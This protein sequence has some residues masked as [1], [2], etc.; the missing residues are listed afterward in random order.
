MERLEG[1][2]PKGPQWRMVSLLFSV[3]LAAFLAQASGSLLAIPLGQ[4]FVP[5]GFAL[6]AMLARLSDDEPVARPPAL[7]LLVATTFSLAIGSLAL[8][9]LN[10]VEPGSL[11]EP[12][13]EV[14]FLAGGEGRLSFTIMLLAVSGSASAVTL[15]RAVR[16]SLTDIIPID[17]ELTSHALGLS[18]AV[19]VAIVP[20]LPLLVLGHAPF[21]LP[22]GA[23]PEDA[24]G[25]AMPSFVERTFELGWFALATLLVAGPGSGRSW[26]AVIE[27]LGLHAP[28][29][30]HLI[31][32][33]VAGV[34][35]AFLRP[36]VMTRIATWMAVPPAAVPDGWS[37]G[38]LSWLGLV[39]C[40]LVTATG[41][42]LT[43][44]GLLQPRLG[45]VF[46]NLVWIAPL[47]W[48]ASWNV[49]FAAFGAGLVFG[50]LR[51]ASGTRAA[52]VAHVMFLVSWRWWP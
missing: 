32:A 34:A 24:A 52:W 26:R 37:P 18:A 4:A 48:A 13:Q 23:L 44:R 7:L 17:P 36:L 38:S 43:F 25:L 12:A 28:P 22:I 41:T 50:A 30:W 16:A 42:E 51:M 39:A 9:V 31:V 3:V 21:P 49:L 29:P 40:A 47:A 20:M 19:A 2:K 11:Q 45:I 15:F 8:V 35:L 46:T 6:L 5:A 27:R 14:E 33:A 1:A 10:V